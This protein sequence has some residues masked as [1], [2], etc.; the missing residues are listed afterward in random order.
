MSEKRT[1]KFIYSIQNVS[2]DIIEYLQ[3]IDCEYHIY[4]YKYNKIHGFILFKFTK[5]EKAASKILNTPVSKALG[6]SISIITNIKTMENVWDIGNKPQRI[7]SMQNME[8]RLNE[9]PANVFCKFVMKQNNALLKSAIEDKMQLQQQ[10]MELQKAM[11]NQTSMIQSTLANSLTNTMTNSHNTTDNS[12]NKKITNINLFLN[13][14]CKDA[15]TLN[16]FIS[17]LQIEDED[18]MCMKEHG[19]I[20][21]VS[22]LLKRA[23]TEYDLYK[24]PIHC[25]DVKREV[26][27]VK[28][29]EGWKKETPTGE[30]KNIN[31]AFRHISHLHRKKMTKYYKDVEINTKQFDEKANIMY[32]IASAGGTDEDVY[33]KKIIKNI[34]EDVRL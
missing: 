10:N 1:R 4:G 14:K 16:D 33:K 5:T 6:E 8:N 22:N 18:L 24:R 3:S 26:L 25:S 29:Q 27:H 19:Y 31:K 7:K 15:I 13:T 9:L 34:V 28:D 2:E 20:E 30:S 17:N 21:S 23:L 32:K 11:I 12:K